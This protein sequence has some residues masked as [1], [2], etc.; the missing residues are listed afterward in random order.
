M[1]ELTC[2]QFYLGCY[3]V[4][5]NEQFLVLKSVTYNSQRNLLVLS[6]YCIACSHQSIVVSCGAQTGGSTVA[7]ARTL[8]IYAKNKAK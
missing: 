1:L 4:K 8:K 5:F 2:Y 6:E 7:T 3:V